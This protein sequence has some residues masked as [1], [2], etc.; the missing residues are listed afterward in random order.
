MWVQV[1]YNVIDKNT[2][3]MSSES[4]VVNG[5]DIKNVEYVPRERFNIELHDGKWLLEGVVYTHDGKD[6][7]G[8]KLKNLDILFRYL[9]VGFHIDLHDGKWLLGDK[10]EFDCWY[11]KVGRIERMERNTETPQ[12]PPF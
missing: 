5:R 3:L 6:G 7:S 8:H 11:D 4:L 12:K 10:M 1:I 9:I 2:D